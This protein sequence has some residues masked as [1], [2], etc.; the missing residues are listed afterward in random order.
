MVLLGL[1][2][3][4]MLTKARWVKGLTLFTFLILTNPIV[5]N[6]ATA[7]LERDFPPTPLAAI[8][9]VDTVIVLGGMVVPIRAASGEVMYEFNTA[10]DRIEA[11]ITLLQSGQARHLILTRGQLPWSI[12]QP[13]GEF[14]RDVAI[15][16]GVAP[17]DITLTARAENTAQEAAAIAGLIAPGTRVGLV[18]SAFHMPRALGIFQAQGMDVTPIAVDY[19][20]RFDRIT[21]MDFIPSAEAL[22]DLSLVLREMIGRA[23]YALRS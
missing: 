17:Q 7:A 23:Y 2:L 10:A 18:T 20:Q 5:A 19:R 8:A 3:L 22:D 4:S 1:V 12:G 13:E 14:L 16:R 11:G 9:P 21:V 15:A 6:L